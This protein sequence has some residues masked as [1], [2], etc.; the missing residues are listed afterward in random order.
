MIMLM[1][2]KRFDASPEYYMV[3]SRRLVPTNAL[4]TGKEVLLPGPQ[5][6]L[7]L[8]LATNMLPLKTSLGLPWGGCS[9]P[10]DPSGDVLQT[11]SIGVLAATFR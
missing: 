3:Q 11:S 5:R 2:S 8:V 6:L 7:S 1:Q 10:A 9:T 4:S